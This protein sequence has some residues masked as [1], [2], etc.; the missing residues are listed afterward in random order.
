MSSI[1][2]DKFSSSLILN[3]PPHSEAS[4]P[5]GEAKAVEPN[6]IPNDDY[7]NIV[8]IFWDAE[9]KRTFFCCDPAC[10]NTVHIQREKD[11]FENNNNFDDDNVECENGYAGCT[12]SG[13]WK[14]LGE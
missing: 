6:G 14:C 1:V 13:C 4:E 12:G 9:N 11:Y 8:H 10:T 3:D 5:V 7:S 2:S